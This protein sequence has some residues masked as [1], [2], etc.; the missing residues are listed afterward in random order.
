[1]RVVVRKTHIIGRDFQRLIRGEGDRWATT[2]VP[3][4]GDGEE[5]F[6]RFREMLQRLDI[7]AENEDEAMLRWTRNETKDES[8]RRYPTSNHE[9]SKHMLRMWDLFKRHHYLSH[10][11]NDCIHGHVARWNGEPVG[12]VGDKP[13]PGVREKGS[14]GEDG[15]GHDASR[16]VWGE[17][18]TVI[19]PEYQGIGIG[20]RLS[21][22]V[23][24]YR[25][26]ERYYCVRYISRT[27]HPRFGRYRE[28]SPLW[29]A[30]A[31]NKTAY[32]HTTIYP[33][34]RRRAEVTGVDPRNDGKGRNCVSF[35]HEWVGDEVD[36]RFI[37]IAREHVRAL[38][39]RD[40]P[41]LDLLAAVREGAESHRP[42]LDAYEATLKVCNAKEETKRE[43]TYQAELS[44]YAAKADSL[45]QLE[46]AAASAEQAA[47]DARASASVADTGRARLS[48]VEA[49]E[50]AAK[51]RHLSNTVRTKANPAKTPVPPAAASKRKA[52]PS[53]AV[54]D[55]TRA[56]KRPAAPSLMPSPLNPLISPDGA[57][58]DRAEASKGKS[59]GV[60]A[61]RGA[62]APKLAKGQLGVA[63]FFS[64]RH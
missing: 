9:G 54:G 1:M 64:P 18:R 63:A 51:L 22:A 59:Q 42:L 55:E 16:N 56:V 57:S 43:R 20:S 11:L 39:V 52:S 28:A 44:K 45:A 4:L 17:S 32:V 19:L 30:T 50:T 3:N 26:R 53:A 33:S 58:G 10:E 31:T 46:T 38:Y 25:V 14:G 12:F 2:H 6:E 35:S 29:E 47:S 15:G 60:P 23:A 37:E 49:A 41:T 48:A 62:P 8:G 61:D 34:T 40:K 36:R 27:A 5:R 21:N 13:V 7:G 24:A